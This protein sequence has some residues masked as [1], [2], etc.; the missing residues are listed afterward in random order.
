MNEVR[1]IEQKGSGYKMKN[2]EFNQ[3]Q[4][5]TFRMNIQTTFYDFYQHFVVRYR[6]RFIYL[7]RSCALA[8]NL[9]KNRMFKEQADLFLGECERLDQVRSI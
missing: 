2:K 3:K 7:D 8:P 1:S 4:K 6:M 5:D 9:L